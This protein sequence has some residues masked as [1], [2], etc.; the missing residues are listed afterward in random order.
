MRLL[1][2]LLF[3]LSIGEGDLVEHLL[4]RMCGQEE[5]LACDE[6]LEVDRGEG[7]ADTFE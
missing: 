5:E 4:A 1:Q 7:V 2:P 6:R 3:Q